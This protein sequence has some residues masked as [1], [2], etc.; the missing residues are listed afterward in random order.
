MIGALIIKA[1]EELNICREVIV[2]HAIICS[3]TTTLDSGGS[4]DDC[5][6]VLEL[7]MIANWT[8]WW[9]YRAVAYV[10]VR[11]TR[12]CAVPNNCFLDITHTSRCYV[13]SVSCYPKPHKMTSVPVYWTPL[14]P[15]SVSWV[16]TRLIP[17]F[18]TVSC[19]C[20]P[21]I[22][23]FFTVSCFCTPL[24]YPF[25]IVFCDRSHCS[26]HSSLCLVT[27]RHLSLHYDSMLL[28]HATRHIRL[29]LSD[30][31]AQGF[32]DTRIRWVSRVLPICIIIPCCFSWYT[33][34]HIS[35]RLSTILKKR[36][37]LWTQALELQMQQ[38]R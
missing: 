27:A 24:I 38:L 23:P 12:I 1:L 10:F 22:P 13:T 37:T 31:H 21:L 8:T 17:P 15:A 29:Y 5:D 16:W 32:G 3:Y 30:L 2:C 36:K 20:T 34:V 7:I 35:N 6:R 26:L 33:Y 19:V 11:V 25:I 18:T 28:L 4:Y 9:N 14:I